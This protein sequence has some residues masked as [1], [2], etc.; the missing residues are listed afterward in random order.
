M[1]DSNRV[2]MSYVKEV[3][4]GITPASNLQKLNYTSESLKGTATS[5]QSGVISSDGN[6]KDQIRTGYTADG[7]INTELGH[8]YND[9][10][11]EGA[12]RSAFETPISLSGT[13]FS[14]DASGSPVTLD[15]S[16]N[17][18]GGLKPNDVIM[19][20]GFTTAGNNGALLVGAN[21]AAGSVDVTQVSPSLTLTT[22]AAGDSVT[23]TTTRLEN[24][25]TDSS[26]SIERYFEDVA[27]WFSFLGMRIDTMTLEL[28]ANAVPTVAF[29]FKGDDH[30]AIT[31]SI[32][33][34]YTAASTNDVIDTVDGYI[35]TLIGND[36]AVLTSASGCVTKITFTIA[37]SQRITEGLNCSTAGKG[38]FD[39][40]VNFDILFTDLTYYKIFQDNGYS[41]LCAA[42]VDGSSQGIAITVP[43]LKYTDATANATGRN[44]DVIGSFQCQAVGT[45]VGSDTY[46]SILSK[47]G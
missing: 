13:T 16:G 35:G 46:T 47:L 8:E 4:Y 6:V 34:G 3:T 28:G 18:L 25:N 29:T 26:F 22:E 31:S 10:F 20:A 19:V 9:E 5:T 37:N 12:F 44:A 45:T 23:A 2:T 14:I 17:G 43:K 39:V 11:I 30:P 27:D 32:G 24:A 33:T 7:G 21:T 36:G 15:D 42:V 40:K 41:S 1:S 38:D